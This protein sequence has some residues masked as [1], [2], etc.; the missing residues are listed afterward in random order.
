M[1]CEMSKSLA[2]LILTGQLPQKSLGGGQMGG[3]RRQLLKLSVL[4]Q[5][6]SIGHGRKRSFRNDRQT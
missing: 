2:Q 5:V 3:Q 4:L 6:K 1:D